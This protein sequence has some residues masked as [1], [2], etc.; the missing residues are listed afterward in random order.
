VVGSPCYCGY[1]TAAL[2]AFMERMEFPAVNY[3][4][5]SKPIV[6][7]KIHSATIYTLNCVNEEFYRMVNYH[8]LMDNSA[9]QLGVFG[10][11]EILRSFDTYQF[12]DYSRYD[13]EAFN[14]EHK[15]QMRDTQFPRD[16]QKAYNLG[17]R[18][19][20]RSQRE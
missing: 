6:L 5:Y 13:A 19:V 14:P 20:A 1:P 10:P 7:K 4:D 8:I 18:L 15:A 16:L 9:Q 17:L 3:A 12:N 2:R 11:T